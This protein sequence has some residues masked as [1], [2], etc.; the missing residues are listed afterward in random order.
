MVDAVPTNPPLP[1]FLINRSSFDDA[2][3]RLNRQHGVEHVE[4]RVTGVALG[5]RAPHRVSVRR[6]DGA[7]RT[8]EARWLIDATGRRRLLAKQLGLVR[9]VARQRSSFWFR[10]ADFDASILERVDGATKGLPPPDAYHAAHHFFGAGHWLWLLPLRAADGRR[11]IS[12]G[13]T[14]RPDLFGDAVTCMPDALAVPDVPAPG[15]VAPAAHAAGR[16]TLV[17]RPGAARR[18]AALAGL[19]RCRRGIRQ[20]QSQAEPVDLPAGRHELRMAGR[21]LVPSGRPEER[22]SDLKAARVAYIP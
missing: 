11:L 2:L 9:G 3:R 16:G 15:R 4:G 21:A 7:E 13:L 5:E 14:H 22:R 10:L 8:C 18:A 1:S 20:T 17:V 6:A 12:V 19:G